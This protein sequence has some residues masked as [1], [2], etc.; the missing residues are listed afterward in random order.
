M[1]VF[2]SASSGVGKSTIIDELANRGYSAYDADDR[3][4]HLTRLEIRETGEPVEWP[5]GYVDWHYYSWNASEDTLK[6]LLASD[7]TVIIAGFL[8]NQEKLYHYFDKLIALTIEPEEHERRLRTRPKRDVGDD[9]QN[10]IRRLE[11]Y[12]MHMEKFLQTGFI[13]VDNSGSVAQTVDQIE[14]IIASH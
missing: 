8:G 4:L 12:P 13:P 9:E 7:D 2:I 5:Q 3:S 14:Q 11:K 10:I 6:E 1:K